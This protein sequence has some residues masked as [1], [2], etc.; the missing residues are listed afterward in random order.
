MSEIGTGFSRRDF[1]GSGAALVA[2]AAYP[3]ALGAQVALPPL[4][5]L[6][7][8][9]LGC[10]LTV[11][12]TRNKEHQALFLRHFS[13]ITPEWEMK[14]GPIVKED[15]SYRLAAADALVAYAKRH[16]MPLHAHTLVWYAHTPESFK[17]LDGSGEPFLEAYRRY[18]STVSRRYRG[19]VRGWDVLNEPVT[20]DGDELRTSLWSNNLGQDEHM[21]LAFDLA[22]EGDPEAVLFINEYGLEMRPNKRLTYLRLIERLLKRGAKIEGIGTQSHMNLDMAPGEARKTIRDL[23]SFGLPVHVSEVDVTLGKRRIEPEKLPE[24]REKQARQVDELLDAF[25]A[26]P[27]KQKYAFTFWGLRDADSWWRKPPLNVATDEPLLFDD[28]GQ[29]KP[30]ATTVARRLAGKT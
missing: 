24:R 23:A 2:A 1:L 13:Q 3:S 22:K 15:G 6:A 21:L 10:C 9:P 17:K 19:R 29:P 12:Q 18:I 8:F 20:H 30:I 28:A 5:S 11:E 25:L 27:E 16:G 26:L 4:K 14:M 7:S